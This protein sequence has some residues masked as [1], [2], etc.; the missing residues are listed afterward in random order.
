VRSGGTQRAV[1]PTKGSSK[2]PAQAE[3]SRIVG[4][5]TYGAVQAKLEIGQPDDEFERE[6]N[7]VADRILNEQ[8]PLAEDNAPTPAQAQPAVQ[9]TPAQGSAPEA[10]TA[11]P[12]APAAPAALKPVVSQTAEPAIQQSPLE[13]ENLG[14]EQ[15]EQTPAR[16]KSASSGPPNPPDDRNPNSGNGS[17]LSSATRHGQPLPRPV[18]DFFQP[19]FGFDFSAVR[20]HDGPAAN[21]AG[22]A[23]RAKA[24]TSGKEI[25]FGA[26]QYAPETFEGRRL[27]AHELTHIVQQNAPPAI[28]H[29]G[30]LAAHSPVELAVPASDATRVQRQE[31]E[32][33]EETTE[34]DT[35]SPGQAPAPADQVL[36]DE[37]PISRRVNYEEATRKNQKWFELL[38]L[39][40]VNPFHPYD[41]YQTPIAFANRIIRWQA[42][43]NRRV[44]GV[45]FSEIVFAA[46]EAQRGVR[47]NNVDTIIEGI[48]DVVTS[49]KENRF[50]PGSRLEVD[51]VIGPRTYWTTL[52]A[53][54][55]SGSEAGT[56]ILTVTR[57]PIDMLRP[58]NEMDLADIQGAWRAVHAFLFNKPRFRAEWETAVRSEILFET[59]DALHS[60]GSGNQAF[61]MSLFFPYEVPEGVEIGE[62]DL[63]AILARGYAEQ[64]LDGIATIFEVDRSY[65][66]QIDIER[67]VMNQ[68]EQWR[69]SMTLKMARPGARAR[70]LI[71]QLSLQ[72]PA[73]RAAQQASERL[74]GQQVDEHGNLQT[75]EDPMAVLAVIYRLP[76]KDPFFWLDLAADYA[77][78]KQLLA[79]AAEE[80][81]E[82]HLAQLQTRYE[83][84]MA[85]TPDISKS[86]AAA[87]LE[88]LVGSVFSS[89]Q[90]TRFNQHVQDAQGHD[91][92]M[93]SRLQSATATQKVSRLYQ[94]AETDHYLVVQLGDERESRFPLALRQIDQARA[95][96]RRNGPNP[97]LFDMIDTPHAA[98]HL[99][100]PTRFTA[101]DVEGGGAQ[102]A[103][104]PYQL[105]ER[106][107]RRAYENWDYY[108]T[109]PVYAPFEPVLVEVREFNPDAGQLF[110]LGRQLAGT[111]RIFLR[112]FWTLGGSL[113]PLSDQLW[114]AQGTLNLFGW[115]DAVLTIGALATLVAAPL[116]AGGEAAAGTAAA[117]F[118]SAAVAAASRRA[119]YIALK[120]FVISEALG[121]ALGRFTFYLNDD[122][123]VPQEIKTVWN[124]LMVAML[125]YGVGS[126]VKQ[127]IKSFRNRGSVRF[128]RELELLEAEIEAEIRA[129]RGSSSAA[130]NVAQA[131]IRRRTAEQHQALT[132]G[133]GLETPGG[134]A[135][136]RSDDPRAAD[137]SS[138]PALEP[139]LTPQDRVRLRDALG[140]DVATTLADNMSDTARRRLASIADNPAISKLAAALTPA[141]LSRLLGTVHPVVL[142]LF[143]NALDA[144]TLQTVLAALSRNADGV[145]LMR[146]FAPDPQRLASLL[147][148][149]GDRQLLSFAGNPGAD[150]FWRFASRVDS[151]AIAVAMRRMGVGRRGSVARFRSLM[152]DIGPELTSEVLNMYTAGEIRAR[153]RRRRGMSAAQ[154][155]GRL[156]IRR[157]GVAT[158]ARQRTGFAVPEI[159]PRPRT[160]DSDDFPS[161]YAVGPEAA[162]PPL[163]RGTVRQIQDATAQAANH[164][165]ELIDLAVRG[166]LTDIDLQAVPPNARKTVEAFLRTGPGDA[167]HHALYGSALQYMSEAALREIHGGALPPGLAIRRR[168]VREGQTLIPDAQ[169]ELTLQADLRQPQR[170]T[171]ERLVVDWTT[172]G[173]AGKITKYI[174]GD[175]PVTWA[176]EVVQPGPPPRPAQPAQPVIPSMPTGATDPDTEHESD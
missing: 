124:G 90:Q 20:V 59:F 62:E 151:A 97:L 107:N 109:A 117:E 87:F 155:L 15:E 16:L 158:Q 96:A 82:A 11:L 76:D 40:N 120:R 168:E 103:S 66:H 136:V 162:A 79:Q 51:G 23:L 28:G 142:R 127:G 132:E 31:V 72:I 91:V 100:L 32:P 147:T 68:D 29:P 48:P 143:A 173:E 38:G 163:V 27:L 133:A 119:L 152:R 77:L 9:A 154:N 42:R 161:F 175:P 46:E 113:V 144:Q 138:R 125:A 25:V 140:D 19:R 108:S 160:F 85:G 60:L 33:L 129:G 5:A 93:V 44:S 134:A 115:I 17:L 70:T 50:R 64:S 98:M 106:P 1:L 84:R 150:P 99:Y 116:I 52:V 111:D 166:M 24:F 18:L 145:A 141:E 55:L 171:T 164:L 167:N 69:D 14:P 34:P 49:L 26:N 92:E 148:D 12:S 6:A 56:E 81:T 122:P 139:P 3:L 156:A 2:R 65:F 58:L 149:L 89:A 112:Y 105:T 86:D 35:A 170:N 94:K 80:A 169:I 157:R 104:N 21:T 74:L 88:L 30:N 172:Q 137:V 131:D 57:T 36:E 75:G 61:L 118:G 165:D 54:A 121:E 39:A 135:R 83:Q 47:E 101:R 126:T 37:E 114:S 102:A 159:E 4:N 128:R 53:G 71:D 130:D 95:Q 41:P 8:T 123:D 176:V 153:W 73:G 10:K 110:R 13:N 43:I 78:E 7:K 22:Q 45:S 146:A 63:L 67:F 174:G